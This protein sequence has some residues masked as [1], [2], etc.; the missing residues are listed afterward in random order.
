MDN[1]KIGLFL[2]GLRTE[3]NMTQLELA[4]LLNVTHQSVSK[5]ENGD[6]IGKSLV[7][8]KLISSHQT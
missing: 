5:W 4:N 7:K 6:S 3:K 8:L 2:Q 1:R